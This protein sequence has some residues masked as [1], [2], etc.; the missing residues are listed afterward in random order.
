MKKKK[1]KR[2]AD[3]N[4][5]CKQSNEKKTELDTKAHQGFQQ[6]FERMQGFLK[7]GKSD[8]KM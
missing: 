5:R 8:E 6:G 7:K 2:K 3:H 1:R 4:F